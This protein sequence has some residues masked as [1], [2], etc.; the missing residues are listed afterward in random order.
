MSAGLAPA[1]M[2][3]A[4]PQIEKEG[5]VCFVEAGMYVYTCAPPDESNKAR[6]LSQI[7]IERMLKTPTRVLAATS[8]DGMRRSSARA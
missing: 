7:I 8:K 2:L 3:A 4:Q 1:A 5:P 6:K